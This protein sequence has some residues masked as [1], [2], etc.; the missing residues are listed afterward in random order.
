MGQH[1]EAIGLPKAGES[2]MKLIRRSMAKLLRNRI[3]KADWV[4]VGLFLGH[5]KLDSVS[6]IYAPFDPSHCAVARQEIE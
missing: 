4:E 5:R 6:D 3:A 2:G 1:A